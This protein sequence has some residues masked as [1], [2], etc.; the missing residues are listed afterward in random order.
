MAAV[1]EKILKDAQRRSNAKYGDEELR[2]FLRDKAMRTVS[3]NVNPKKIIDRKNAE[4]ISVRSI[5]PG[6]MICYFYDA[7]TKDDLPYWDKFPV[8]FPIEIYSDGWLGINMHYLPPIFRARL[9][10]KLHDLVTNEKYND[11]TRLRISYDILNAAAKFK[12]FKPCIK[13]YL[14]GQVRSRVIKV[15]PAEWDYAMMLPLARFQK[16]KAPKVWDDSI[17]QIQRAK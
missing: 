15:H 16:A 1:F 11:F 2:D 9:M 17:K 14:A 3:K 12:Y 8:I 6:D 13:R 5:I 4:E 7:K 10:D